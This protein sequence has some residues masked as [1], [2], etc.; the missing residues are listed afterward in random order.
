MKQSLKAAFISSIIVL[1]WSPVVGF[2]AP[3][4]W[5]TVPLAGPP[6][7]VE[8]PAVTANFSGIKVLGTAVGC[9]LPPRPPSSAEV[10][11]FGADCWLFS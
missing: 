8:V 6:P 11:G 1:P 3:S 7:V 2:T 5:T 4:H 10:A 9:P